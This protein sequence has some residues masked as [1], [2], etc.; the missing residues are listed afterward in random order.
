[1]RVTKM[2]SLDTSSTFSGYCLYE[3]AVRVESGEF[4]HDPKIEKNADIRKENMCL[5][6]IQYL[7]RHK[8]VIVVAELTV[9]PR[10]AGSQRLLS[11]ILGV[12]WGWCLCNAA[13]FVT[14]RP[15]EWRR[16]VADGE[17]V[18]IRREEAKAWAIHKVSR[19]YGIHV[20]DNEAEAILI[21]QARINQFK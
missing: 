12:I 7:N 10:N 17:S 19:L 8:P 4:V 21:G 9:V 18:P 16:L 15:G 5:D 6:I 20:T 1:M 11:E 3:N 14:F 2:V 13:E